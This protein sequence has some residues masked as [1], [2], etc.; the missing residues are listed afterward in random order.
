VEFLS[1]RGYR[2][3]HSYRQDDFFAPVP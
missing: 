2:R 3:T 1:A